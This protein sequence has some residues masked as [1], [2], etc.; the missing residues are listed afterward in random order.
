MGLSEP[1]MRGNEGILF[2]VEGQCFIHVNLY[3]TD[4][5]SI[6]TLI[7]KDLYSIVYCRPQTHLESVTFQD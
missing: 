1:I 3:L 6:Y 5:S 2:F 7:Y 4:F